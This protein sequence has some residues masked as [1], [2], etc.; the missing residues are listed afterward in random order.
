MIMS[1]FIGVD[2]CRGGWLAVIA[3]FHNRR[4]QRET[5]HKYSLFSELLKG[6]SDAE[7]IAIDI[8]I[9]LLDEPISGGRP[10]D[11]AARKLLE[12]TRKSSI[13]SPPIRRTLQATTYE[14]ANALNDGMS[15]QSFGI[16]PKIREVDELMTP[17]MQ[18]RVYEVHPE[19][20]F[21]D[22]AGRCMQFRKKDKAGQDE[23]LAILKS[24]GFRKVES[25]FSAFKRTQVAIDDILDA[26]ATIFTAIKIANGTAK[27]TSKPQYDSKGLRMG[28]WL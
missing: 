13:F 3:E 23:R 4:I 1:K 22:K 15:R 9:G 10:C 18:N 2:G 24:A 12:G 5:Y 17:E 20:C 14:E 7:V 25:A 8:P 16:L 28:I 21:A 26:C 27:C 19:I 6:N 11:V